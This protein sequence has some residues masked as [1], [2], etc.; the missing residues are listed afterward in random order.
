VTAFLE[1]LQVK[2]HPVLQNQQPIIPAVARVLAWSQWYMRNREDECSFVSLRDVERAMIVFE[3][4]HDKME[5]FGPKMDSMAARELEMEDEEEVHALPRSPDPITRSLLL[6]ISVCYHARLQEREDYEE[7]V[8]AQ[9]VAPLGLPGGAA[10][11]RNEIQC[12]QEVLLDSMTLGPNIAKNAA[13]RENV[14]M[15]AICIELR[16][17]LFLVGKPGSSKSLAKSIVQSSMQ[18]TASNSELLRGFKQVHI[19]SYQCSQLSTPESVIEVFNTA[20]R[21]Q[22]NQDTSKYVSVVVLD[23]VG[24]A[25][26]SPNLPL[27]ALHPLLEDGTEGADEKSIDREKRV[28]FIGISN[29]ALDPAK[30]NRGVMVTR[31]NPNTKE[32]QLSARGIC[33][34]REDDPVKRRLEGYFEPLAKA[35][36]KICRKQKR[37]FFGLRDFYR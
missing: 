10:Q 18:G 20:K 22:R 24:L 7:G 21:F 30:M 33:S 17:P 27:K 36:K 14:F 25:E 28:A 15:M 29:W 26:D 34:N 2:K 9:F 13:L 8:A 4:F 12:C 1:P 23:E 16:I 6:A 32:L 5:V 11:F 35:Y 19:F 3:Y 31:G 37:E